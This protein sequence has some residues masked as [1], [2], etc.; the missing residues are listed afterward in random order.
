[1]EKRR[2]D[3]VLIEDG[4]VSSRERA[5]GLILAGRVYAD[6]TKRD[7]PSYLVC[8]ESTI[9]VREDIC[10]YVSRGGFKLEKGLQSFAYDV[11]GKV[12]IDVGAS[13]GGFTDCLLQHGAKKVYAVDVG[14][15]QLAFSLRNDD[16]VVV[17][18]RQNARFLTKEMFDPDIQLA[19]MDAAFIS[20]QLLI[21]PLLPILCD[22]GDIIALIKPQFEAGKDKVGKKGVVRDKAVHVEVIE[23]IITFVLGLGLFVV[24]LDYSPIKGPNGNI[25][26]LIYLSKKPGTVPI[27]PQISSQIVENAHLLLR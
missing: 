9:E 27:N 4:H 21:P 8:D 16:R 1:M 25:E 19:V 3:V 26:Y 6:G 24:S 14:Y 22:D 17:M 20:I 15:G 12:C 10:P 5:K 2:L 7:K 11:Q 18:E 13:T 23:N